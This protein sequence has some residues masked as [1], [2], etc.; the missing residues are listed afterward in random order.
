MNT[1]T[2]VLLV[3]LCTVDVVQRVAD[4]PGPGGKVQSV[5]VETVAGGP[6]A[7]AAVAVAALGGRAQLVTALGAHPLAALARDDLTAHGVRVLDVCPDRTDPPA[8]SAVAVRERDGERVVVSHNAAGIAAPAA[9]AWPDLLSGVGALLVDGHHPDLAV[10][11]ARA[12]RGRRVPVLLDAGSDKAVLSTLL[13][14]VDVCACSAGFRLGRA[15]AK[16]T[17]R[18]VHELGVP[19]V[20]RTGGGGPVRWSADGRGGDVKPPPVAARDTLGAG[21]VWHGALAHGVAALGRVPGAADLPALVDAANRVAAARVARVGARA[22][23]A[24]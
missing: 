6:A 21:D 4:L 24:G 18:A 22:W 13:P 11:A 12:A 5:S 10:A 15:G 7:N 1:M 23:V 19:V 20:L 3:G 16:A 8:V 2:A 17:E 14:L 9:P